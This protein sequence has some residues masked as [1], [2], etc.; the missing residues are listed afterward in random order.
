MSCNQAVTANQLRLSLEAKRAGFDSPVL[1]V[2]ISDD[3]QL[4]L[5]TNTL[6]YVAAQQRPELEVL[7][8]LRSER[9]RPGARPGATAH[10]GL[11]RCDC[12]AA[13][14]SAHVAAAAMAKEAEG[15]RQ[16]RRRSR[17]VLRQ[18]LGGEMWRRPRRGLL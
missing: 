8:I 17:R 7:S 13:L 4:E 2:P 10:L 1:F 11:T 9:L 14:Q 18:T 6:E 16:R 15:R 5:C 3:A 12:A